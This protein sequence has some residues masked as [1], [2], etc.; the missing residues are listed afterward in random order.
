MTIS[1][2]N[3]KDDD[4]RKFAEE[5]RLILLL[6]EYYASFLNGLNFLSNKYY[7]VLHQKFKIDFGFSR[8]S[9]YNFN[10]STKINN[11]LIID[12]VAHFHFT[13]IDQ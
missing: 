3:T 9:P 8:V 11:K 6:G 2:N 5:R 1:R 7:S 13:F 4:P 12:F 10:E